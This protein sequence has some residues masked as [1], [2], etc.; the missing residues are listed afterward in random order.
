MLV[1]ERQLDEEA[2]DRVVGVQLLDLL[3]QLLLG[4]VCGE[5]DV[6]RVDADL[7]G[8]LVLQPDVD[9]RGGVVADEDRRQTD[10]A[11]PAHLLGDLAADAFRERLPVHQPSRHLASYAFT[12]ARR[13]D[14]PRGPSGDLRRKPG[15]TG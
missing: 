4:R 13:H 10:L 9:V 14:R 15:R 3:E 11:Q 8:S 7:A 6:P 1:R 12:D 5:P 2:V